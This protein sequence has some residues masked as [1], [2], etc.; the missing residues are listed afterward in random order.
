MTKYLAGVLTV[1]AAGVLM[2]AYGLLAPGVSASYRRGD[3]MMDMSATTV[4]GQPL[5]MMPQGMVAT[6]VA[7]TAVPA[8]TLQ[9]AVM[10][11]AVVSYPYAVP[12]SMLVPVRDT[13]A[14]ASPTP[15][16]RAPR[17]Q[18]ASL[19][20]VERPQRDW[21]KTALMIGGSSAAGA[22]LG[23][24]FGGKKGALIGAAIGGGASTIYETTKH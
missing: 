14:V 7:M 1:I 16:A 19:S 13:P 5:M 24:I 11:P 6:P 12:A 20:R 18:R 9:P 21:K 8:G 23:G 10:Q 3:P 4:S 2:I 15:T 22:G 17:A